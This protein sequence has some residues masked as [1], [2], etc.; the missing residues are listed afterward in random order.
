[1]KQ[2]GLFCL[3][4]I[5]GMQSFAQE[6]QHAGDVNKN[7]TPYHDAIDAQQGI[8]GAGLEKQAAWQQFKQHHPGWGADFSRF[9]RLPHRAFGEPITFAPGGNDPVAK[10]KAFLQQELSGFNLPLQELV[11]TRNVNDGKYIHVDFKQIHN[12]VEVLWSRV[13]VRFTQDLRIVMLC[14]DAHRNI[15]ALSAVISPATAIQKAEL[16]V[17]TPVTATTVSN[18]LK[19]FPYPADGGFE[20]KL[21]YAVTVNTQDDKE[22][23]GMYLTY[24]DAAN[25]D[26]LYRQN[27]VKHL[28]F[29]V[30]ADAYMTNLFAPL[31]NLPLKNLKVNVNGVDYYTDLNGDVNV[32]SSVPVDPTITLSGKYIAVVTGANGTIS[33]TYSTLGVAAGDTVNYPHSSPDATE[34]HMTCYYHANEIH[35]FMK[36]KFPTFT[37]MD[38]PLRARVDRTDGNCN[39]FYNGTSI[40]FYTTANGCNALSLIS[41]VM[42]HEYGHGI[43][44]VFWDDQGSSFDNGAQGEGYSDVWAIGLTHSPLIGP[45][46]YIGQP[47]STIRRYDINPK[48]YPQDIVGE[49]HADGEIIAGAWW[50]TGVNWGSVDSMADLFAKSHYGLA[51]GPDGTEGQVYHDILI[52]ALQYDD[53]NANI[54][55]GTPHFTDIVPAFAAHGI[56]LLSNTTLS[57]QS[58]GSISAATPVTISAVAVSDF[59]AFVG[60]VKMIYR[61]KGTT[62]SDTLLMTKSGANYTCQFPAATNGDVYEY[63]FAVYDYT[64][65]LSLFSPANS[66]FST[67]FTQRNIPYYLLVGYNQVMLEPFTNLTSTSSGWIVGNA[68]NDNATS[69]KWIIDVPIS[70]VTNGDTIQTGKDHTTG[71]GKCA[72]TGNAASAASAP[73]NAD[74][75]GGRTTLITPEF[76][77]A[78][79]N[80]PVISYWRWFSNSQASTNPGK[81]LWR[82][83]ISYNNGT[84]W[85]MVERTYKPDVQWRR[86]VVVADLSQGSTA[87]LMFTATDSTNATITTGTWVEAAID[88][89][90]ILEL[91]NGSVGVQ[92]IS[93]LQ[94]S[95]YPNP[96]N[97]E[98][99]IVTPEQGNLHYEVVNAV[100]EVLQSNTLAIQG[101]RVK[102]NT[103]SL[104]AGMYFVKLNVDGK[105]SVQRL[106]IAR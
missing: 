29:N 17:V 27:Q 5:L 84:T 38:N 9:T 4:L 48:V 93:T 31:S 99:T 50:D 72:V 47:A 30:R 78:A 13:G 35:D 42:Y 82:V 36:T 52:D 77:L 104:A 92:E 11:M 91:G 34:R 67:G 21:A 86:S 6:H 79:Y 94:A 74:V 57:H 32:P 55:D 90:E 49:V 73:G 33:P 100:G 3:S 45:G 98:V 28:G 15:P 24:V 56:F 96:A 46:F 2:F 61:K 10:A 20:Y 41:D 106:M 62:V 88:D 18:D 105:Q 66:A 102:L 83:W 1:M 97:Q 101:N 40:N 63:I 60:D 103:A 54:A 80:K 51:T 85:N 37:A 75:D 7:I 64:N 25:G 69:G 87:K 43:T 81:D 58:P 95:L 59:P 76:N 26:I 68:P 23:P 70:S 8:N 16:A 39:A 19:I 44:N 22:T 53:D 12:G 14:V 89:I 71:T 65:A